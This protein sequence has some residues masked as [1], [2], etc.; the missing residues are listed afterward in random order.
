MKAFITVLTISLTVCVFTGCATEYHVSTSGLDDNPGT[1]SKPFKTIMAAAHVAQPGDTI[2]VGEGTYRESINPPRGGTS[3]AKRIVYQAAPGENVVIKGSEVIKGWQPVG[4]GVWKVTLPN[5]FFGEFNPYDDLVRGNWFRPKDRNHHTGAVYLNGQ[6]RIEAPILEDVLDPDGLAK[7]SDKQLRQQ[8]MMNVAWVRPVLRNKNSKTIPATSF[9]DQ[10]GVQTAPCTEGGKCISGAKH[11][12]WVEYKDVDFGED[13]LAVELRAASASRGGMVDI[14]LNKPNGRFMGSCFVPNTG[15]DQA[16]DTFTATFTRSVSGPQKLY[17][18]FRVAKPMKKYPADSPLWYSRVDDKNTTIWGQFGKANPNEETA[19]INVRQTIFYPDK[20]GRN[21]IT[22]RGFTLRD[23]A[24]NWAPPTAEQKGLI[25]T[26]WSRGW[27]IENNTI[28]HSINTGITLGKYGDEFDNLAWTADAYNGSIERA[29]S[30][31]WKKGSVG[32]HIVRNNSI[33][34]CEQAGIVGSMGASFSQVTGNHIFKINVQGRFTG[35]EMAG[36]KFHAPVDLLVKGNRINDTGL[37]LWLDWMAQG[38]RVTGNL[39][40]NN[41]KDV[42]LEVNHGPCLV[43]SNLFLSSMFLNRSE[44]GAYAHNLFAGEFSTKLDHHRETPYFK[45][46]TNE[47]TGLCKIDTG[48]DRFYNNMFV[49]DGGKRPA[50]K[51]DQP[52]VTGVVGRGLFIYDDW[53]TPLQTGGN[54]YYYGAHPYAKEKDFVSTQTNPAIKLEERDDGVYL[55]ITVDGAQKDRKTKLVTT[56]LLGLAKVPQTRFENTDGTAI[57]IDTDYFGNK[58]NLKTPT[59][60]PFEN[61]GSGRVKLKVW[62]KK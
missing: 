9:T 18:V 15:G 38:T 14:F 44:G 51:S 60:G 55:N 27:I 7:M 36:I 57:T 48:D 19:E 33:S 41:V 24:P 31:G 13:T 52:T 1:E 62:P 16:W 46:H 43:D 30:N 4:K 26:H 49:G 11:G 32:H 8:A 25:G 35:A 6:W 59:A 47:K 10:Q 23:A 45:A 20:P 39:F 37:A 21:Y 12:N 53:P 56:E 29:L 5:T 3:D 54:I 2:T 61:P 42:F 17:V 34:Y 58:R 40:Y 28:S 50:K 22:V